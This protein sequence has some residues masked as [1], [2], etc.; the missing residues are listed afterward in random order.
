MN[1]AQVN[2]NRQPW[3]FDHDLHQQVTRSSIQPEKAY[4]IFEGGPNDYRHVADLYSQSPIQG[5]G[6]GRVEVIYNKTLSGI[7]KRKI[8]LL[9]ERGPDI[10]FQPKW[11]NKNTKEM[12]LR[13]NTYNILLQKSEKYS[14]PYK[15]IK[16]IPAFHGTKK[17]FL[18][19]ILRTGFDNLATTDSGFFGKGIY[20]SSDANYAHR[21]YSDGTLLFNWVALLS[22]FPVISSDVEKLK[23]G[24]KHQNYDAHYALV[25]PYNPKNPR[26]VIYLPVKENQKWIYDELVVFESAQVLP[27]YIVTLTSEDLKLEGITIKMTKLALMASLCNYLLQSQLIDQE[28][29]FILEEKLKSLAPKM[30][31]EMDHQETFLLDIIQNLNV[32][33]E[34]RIEEVLHGRILRL[35]ESQQGDSPRITPQQEILNQKMIKKLKKLQNVIWEGPKST[36]QADLIQMEMANR[37]EMTLESLKNTKSLKLP[38]DI[39]D[40]ELVRTVQ[41]C[42]YLTELDLSFCSKITD[43]GYQLAAQNC[44]HLVSLDVSRSSIKD[45]GLLSF[46]K[47]C[48]QLCEINVIACYRISNIR[49]IY[50][51][52]LKRNPPINL[53]GVIGEGRG[54][55]D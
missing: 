22:A 32:R 30:N 54:M 46:I 6:V 34:K 28:V 17:K 31:Q 18:D 33:V 13:E 9:E 49:Q 37:M 47:H 27:R 8:S 38:Q 16:L 29:R 48:T 4:Y 19:S 40:L 2:P 36:S 7:F 14:S 5:Y 39:T 52:G 41:F 26:E 1:Q 23:G 24:P 51:N 25:T 53:N 21:V 11:Q 15:H 45:L 44:P 35:L 50:I 20:N 55:Y 42:N 3:H 10:F 43:E 12:K